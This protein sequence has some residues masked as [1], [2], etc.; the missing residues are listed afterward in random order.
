MPVINFFKKLFSS[1]NMSWLNV[2]LFAAGAGIYTGIVAII[3]ATENTS[4]RDIAI[5]F[6]W[7]VIFAFIIASNCKKNWEAAL[8]IFVFFV[9]SQPLVF[10]VEV[11]FGQLDVDMALYYYLT[12]WGP[13]TL[14]TL[15][16]GLV[17][18]YISKQNALG[19]IILGLGCAI[20]T[21]L[22]SYYFEEALSNF[23]N[24]ILSSIVCFASIFIMTFAIQKQTRWRATSLAVAFLGT[25]LVGFLLLIWSHSIA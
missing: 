17:A 22:G 19:A 7:W 23:P 4:I 8:K 16:G 20:Q 25:G 24:H 14:C 5:S 18:F 9:I 2:V 15:P 11:V 1:L 12:N 21:S 13:K 3:P 6:E 10:A